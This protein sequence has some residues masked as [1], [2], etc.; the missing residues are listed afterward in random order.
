MNLH[1]KSIIELRALVLKLK[2]EKRDIQTQLAKVDEIRKRLKEL[3]NPY[4]GK[5]LIQ[6]VEEAIKERKF[7]VYETRKIGYH[8]DVKVAIRITKVTPKCIYLKTDGH[9]RERRFSR[10]TGLRVNSTYGDP[11]DVDKA[12]KI[13]EE[14]ENKS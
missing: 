3:E 8:S 6:R 1:E 12:L 11:I 14:H 10:K 13:W 2:N 4:R 5:G 9:D 7:P